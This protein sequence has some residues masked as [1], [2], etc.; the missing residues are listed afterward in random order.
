LY[1]NTQGLKQ[2]IFKTV[3]KERNMMASRS[4]GRYPSNKEEQEFTRL[5]SIVAGMMLLWI[6]LELTA[7]KEKWKSFLANRNKKV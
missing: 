2:I 5:Q 3:W 7:I 4:L 6:S 1:N